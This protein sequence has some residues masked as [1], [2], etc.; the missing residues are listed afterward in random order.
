[1]ALALAT[2]SASALSCS[3]WLDHP[4]MEIWAAAGRMLLVPKLL[5]SLELLLSGPY[6]RNECEDKR[7][8]PG[9]AVVFAV[10]ALTRFLDRFPARLLSKF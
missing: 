8:C 7:Q 5:Q 1:M 3:A 4:T 2:S 9:A 10:D 6:Y